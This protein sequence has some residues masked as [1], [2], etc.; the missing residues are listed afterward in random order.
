MTLQKELKETAPV[1]HALTALN[2]SRSSS[3]TT[4]TLSDRECYRTT[5]PHAALLT[6]QRSS[7]GILNLE[8]RRT[9]NTFP[10]QAADSVQSSAVNTGREAAESERARQGYVRGGLV[11]SRAN[12]LKLR[13]IRPQGSSCRLS[14]RFP[15]SDSVSAAVSLKAL[16]ARTRRFIITPLC[17]RSDQSL[18]D[19]ATPRSVIGQGKPRPVAVAALSQSETGLH[20]AE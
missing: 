2:L 13:P 15:R 9:V 11:G 10:L 3:E 20:S 7:L 1:R 18:A 14:A 19:I 12:V 6:A 16:K 5:S 17:R 4:R 8:I